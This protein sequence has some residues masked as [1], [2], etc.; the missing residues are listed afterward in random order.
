MNRKRIALLAL[1]TIMISSLAP[2]SA[3]ALET[4]SLPQAIQRAKQ[5]LPEV[6]YP[7]NFESSLLEIDGSPVWHLRWYSNDE[8]RGSVD[9]SLNATTGQ[10]LDFHQY[11]ETGEQIYAPIPEYSQDEAYKMAEAFALRVAG[12]QLSECRYQPAPPPRPVLNTRR[13]PQLYYFTFKRF[14]NDIPFNMNTIS[15]AV[16]GDTGKVESFSMRWHDLEFP[17]PTGLVSAEKAEEILRQHGDLQLTYLWPWYEDAGDARPFLAYSTSKAN[18][19]YI[20]A[21]TG[22]LV[23][24]ITHIPMG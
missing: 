6:Q 18:S 20:N 11:H 19:L 24:G 9:V 7:D 17:D 10:L 8:P 5:L 14:V 12:A 15:I 3:M 23:N 22:E 2:I 13:W 16:N 1:V 4:M 21:Q